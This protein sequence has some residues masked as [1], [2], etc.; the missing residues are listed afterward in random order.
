MKEEIAKI[1]NFGRDVDELRPSQRFSIQDK[2][3]QI[4]DLILNKIVIEKKK[5]TVDTVMWRER[6]ESWNECID[7]LEKIK[8]K[9][10]E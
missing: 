4:L 1:I 3:A 8:R 10:K 7:Q 2:S 9:L 6:V 5:C